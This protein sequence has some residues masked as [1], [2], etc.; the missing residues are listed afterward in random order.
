MLTDARPDIPVSG[1]LAGHRIVRDGHTRH[2]DNA[3]LDG[4]DQREVRDHPGEECTFGIARAAQEKGRG[5]QV[6]DDFDAD[7][8]FDGFQAG[9]PDAGLFFTLFGF[10]FFVAAQ[11][12]TAV[13]GFVAVAVVG[14]VVD[15]D[16]IALAAQ[17]TADAPR[18][19]VGGFGEGAGLALLEDHFGQLA[20]R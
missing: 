12:L 13:F 18:H 11:F 17:F 2:L 15:H 5:R 8:G 3:A 9:D 1:Q 7:L 6:V 19:L 4:V 20:R 16:D 10:A 14:F